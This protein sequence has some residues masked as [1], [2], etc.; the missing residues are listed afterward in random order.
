M[1]DPI[2][3]IVN[4]WTDSFEEYQSLQ[5]LFSKV[6]KEEIKDTIYT[7]IINHKHEVFNNLVELRKEK[8]GM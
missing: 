4:E 2:D 5:P 1:E 3:V 6:S 7:N 8:V